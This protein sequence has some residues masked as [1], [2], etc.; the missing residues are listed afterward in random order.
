[1]KPASPNTRGR[2]QGRRRRLCCHSRWHS[3]QRGIPLRF[4]HA[5]RVSK[6]GAR[7]HAGLLQ[8]TQT[9]STATALACALRGGQNE[10][11]ATPGLQ[12]LLTSGSSDFCVGDFRAS[13][14]LNWPPSQAAGTVSPCY[15]GSFLKRCLAD[16]GKPATLAFLGQPLPSQVTHTKPGRTSPVRPNPSLKGSANGRPPGPGRRCSAHCL[17]PGPGVLPLSP[18]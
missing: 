13:R 10:V 4:G 2:R 3:N 17:R 9:R 15:D 6:Q 7:R 11:R 18:P 14:A 1:M 8:F 12:R 16:Q 5:G